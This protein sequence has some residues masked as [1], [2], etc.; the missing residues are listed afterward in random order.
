MSLKGTDDW[1]EISDVR[2][3]D[4]II[5]SGDFG[6]TFDWTFDYGGKHFGLGGSRNSDQ[7]QKNPESEVKVIVPDSAIVDADSNGNKTVKFLAREAGNPYNNFGC[8]GTA[9]IQSSR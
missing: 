6:C 3:G 2:V 8:D 9:L 5:I 7:R 1:R 4:H